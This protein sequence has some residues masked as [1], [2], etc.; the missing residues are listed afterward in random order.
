MAVLTSWSLAYSL[1]TTSCCPAR[2][3]PHSDLN[4]FWKLST[5]SVCARTPRAHTKGTHQGHTPR[6]RLVLHNYISFNALQTTCSLTNRCTKARAHATRS[7]QPTNTARVQTPHAERRADAS[8][9]GEEGVCKLTFDAQIK[10]S[11]VG[12]VMLHVLGQGLNAF[13]EIVQE[14]HGGV[15]PRPSYQHQ[16]LPACP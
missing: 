9:R 4:S 13:A 12:H 2:A 11:E 3:V 6:L 14:K 15:P 7:S 1:F 10:G 16:S 5:V 8:A